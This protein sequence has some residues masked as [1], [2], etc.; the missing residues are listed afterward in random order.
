[1][2]CSDLQVG[3]CQLTGGIPTWLSVLTR[4]TNLDLG[5]NLFLGGT[6]PSE[7]GALTNLQWL[8]LYYNS[9]TGSIPETLTKL[10]Q[11]SSLCVHAVSGI[12]RVVSFVR[13]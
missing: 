13:T 1:M 7:L 11:L 3:F 4:L 5:S 6:I 9:L 10:T 8:G 12:G 2:P